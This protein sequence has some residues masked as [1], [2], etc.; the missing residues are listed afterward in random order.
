MIVTELSLIKVKAVKVFFSSRNLQL[1][2]I[3]RRLLC[4][5]GHTC[6]TQF[7]VSI[8]SFL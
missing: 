3:K 8:S 5:E 4:L 6:W 1:V 2:K 7:L